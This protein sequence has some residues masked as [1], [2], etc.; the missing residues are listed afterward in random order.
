MGL[1][2]LVIKTNVV[3]NVNMISENIM[4][5][6][7][8][9]NLPVCQYVSMKLFSLGIK[10][11]VVQNVKTI[12]ENIMVVPWTEGGKSTILIVPC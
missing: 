9:V 1:A 11:K 3:Q 10:M 5:V 4:P 2:P 6:C 8:H 12:S 7:Q